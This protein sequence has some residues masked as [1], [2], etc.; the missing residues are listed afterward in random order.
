MLNKARIF[1]LLLACLVVFGTLFQTYR[2]EEQVKAD[3]ARED[4]AV[5]QLHATELALAD[6]RQAQAAYVAAGQGS[7]FWMN[8]F[9][10]A[11]SRVDATLRE[12]QQASQANGAETH[13][14]A[15]LEQLEALRTSDRRARNY[16]NNEQFVLASDVIFVESQEII[17]RIAQNVAAARDT[18]I[19][20]ARQSAGTVTRYRQALMAGG[21]LLTLLLMI[22]MPR[23]VRVEET[24]A[25]PDEAPV[26]MDFTPEPV[27]QPA[28]AAAA[29]ALDDAADVCVDIAR[30]L[31]GRDLPGILSRAA[32]AIDAK[33][34]VLWVNDEQGQTLRATMAHGYSDRMLAR[35]GHL[36]VSA[37]NATSLACRTLQ[38]QMVPGATPSNSGALAVPLIS[39]SGC[40]GVL[41]AEVSG[42]RANG[43]QISV[44]RLIAAQL[45]SV[46]RP[47]ATMSSSVAQTG[48]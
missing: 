16:V 12:R 22:V 7:T 33:G 15:A 9:D 4:T 48:A 42:S 5:Q 30:L 18:E 19:F 26:H 6:A 14:D 35:L 23:K 32:A 13:Y 2:F 10:E 20:S 40:V 3:S 21:L 28:E 31:D 24:A 46:I 45:S 38:P 44:A 36:A 1:T 41:S 11:L 25:V 43:H 47:D 37:D 8:H 27:F 34:L 29:P 17:G 39:T